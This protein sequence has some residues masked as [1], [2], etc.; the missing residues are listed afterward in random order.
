MW[1]TNQRGEQEFTGGQNDWTGAAKVA[2]SCQQFLPDAEE[3]CIADE[4]RSCYNCRYRRWNASFFT[5][6]N[7]KTA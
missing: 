4:P 2:A 7:K 1:I 6:V 5:C 3:E